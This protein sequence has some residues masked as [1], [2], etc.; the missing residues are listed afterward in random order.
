MD[1]YLFIPSAKF[2]YYSL[3]CYLYERFYFLFY[4]FIV[5]L[6]HEPKYLP[7]LAAYPL[8]L[9]KTVFKPVF[10]PNKRHYLKSFLATIM[11]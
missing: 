1:N 6:E 4:D 2:F 10:T 3:I 7:F 8:G 5:K 11:N 9:I